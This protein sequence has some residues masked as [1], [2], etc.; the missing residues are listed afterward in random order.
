MLPSYR[1]LLE[2]DGPRYLEGDLQRLGLDW[3]RES[4]GQP[5]LQANGD[6]RSLLGGLPEPV[7][8]ED[9][10]IFGDSWIE[11]IYNIDRPGTHNYQLRAW[12]DRDEDGCF[13]HLT[14]I[15]PECEESELFIDDLLALEPGPFRKRYNLGF[16][17]RDFY[18]RFRL[19]YDPL[20]PDV[21]PFGEFFSAAHCD[22]TDAEQGNCI[23]YGEVEDYAPVPE[24]SSWLGILAFGGLGFIGLRKKG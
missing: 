22:L 4:D 2:S 6:D 5:T 11:A 16:D 23:S 18:S 7:D 12:C 13:D 9:G 21:K 1:T 24:P 10:I 8:D 20:I 15:D 19:T 17:P 14:H 3:D